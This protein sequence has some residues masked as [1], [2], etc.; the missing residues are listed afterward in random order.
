MTFHAFLS[1][2]AFSAWINLPT[3]SHF[4]TYSIYISHYVGFNH[5]KTQIDKKNDFIAMPN[6]N[7]SDTQKKEDWEISTIYTKITLPISK[8]K[9]YVNLP[10]LLKYI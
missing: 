8:D 9:V 1:L 7:E 6:L 2:V 4:V 3:L 10:F 5:E